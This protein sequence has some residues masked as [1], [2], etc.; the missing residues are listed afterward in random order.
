MQIHHQRTGKTNRKAK[1][2]ERVASQERYSRIN[3]PSQIRRRK[4]SKVTRRRK[5]ST[6]TSKRH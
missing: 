5:K 4:T 6:S 1:T 3:Y 2:G